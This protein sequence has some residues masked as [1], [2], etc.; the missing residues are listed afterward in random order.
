MSGGDMSSLLAGFKN[1][2]PKQGMGVAELAKA[3]ERAAQ[4]TGLV[5]PPVDGA[6]EVREA[7]AKADGPTA[8][9]D[10]A[11]EGGAAAERR[12]RPAP[13]REAAESAGIEWFRLRLPKDVAK[14]LRI[15]AIGDDTTVNALIAE[16]IVE[17]LKRG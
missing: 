14:Q 10:A 5:A 16:A 1:A 4:A 7:P 13:K 6:P 11:P 9:V 15:R 17:L 8:S 12:K 3:S 2:K